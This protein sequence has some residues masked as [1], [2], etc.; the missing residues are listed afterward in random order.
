MAVGDAY[1][2]YCNPDCPEH[3]PYRRRLY[4][5]DPPPPQP[6]W[7][8]PVCGKVMAPWMPSCSGTHHSTGPNTVQWSYTTDF[9][10]STDKEEEE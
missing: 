7:Q 10:F 3:S 5:L 8:C 4:Y 6:G 1:Y 2:H 9:S